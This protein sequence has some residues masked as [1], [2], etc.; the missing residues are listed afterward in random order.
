MLGRSSEES[1]LGPTDDSADD[2]ESDLRR[3]RRRISWP[4]AWKLWALAAMTR[5]L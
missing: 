3:V 2:D 4:G 1:V 5:T